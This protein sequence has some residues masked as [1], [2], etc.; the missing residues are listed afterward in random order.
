M[1]TFTVHEPLDPATDLLKRADQL[2]FVKEGVAWFALFF[3]LLWLLVQRMWLVLVLFI[4]AGIGV[5][6][7]T[8]QLGGNEQI[9]SWAFIALTLLFAVQANDLRRWNLSRRGYRMVAAVAGRNRDECERRFF[10]DWAEEAEY[11]GT[12]LDEFDEVPGGWEKEFTQATE[13]A[14]EEP[15]GSD[16]PAVPD[17]P[18]AKGTKSTKS[19]GRSSKK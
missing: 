5:S 10:A 17:K 8:V 19:K 3:P 16:E 13:E 9:A 6:F 12:Y 15:N 4:L 1:K 7:A 14:A 11:D 18:E 2:V